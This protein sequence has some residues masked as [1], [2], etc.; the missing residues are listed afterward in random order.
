MVYLWYQ[1]TI[2]TLGAVTYL[3]RSK[4]IPAGNSPSNDGKFRSQLAFDRSGAIF[5]MQRNTLPSQ[6]NPFDSL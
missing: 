2:K 5:P 4:W 1:L 3:A 6:K